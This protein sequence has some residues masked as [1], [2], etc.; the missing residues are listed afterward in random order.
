MYG[1]RVHEAVIQA[2]DAESGITIHM[3]DELYDHGSVIFQA[4]CPVYPEDTAD[5]LSQENS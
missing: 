1:A 5:T 4:R 3:V 2:K